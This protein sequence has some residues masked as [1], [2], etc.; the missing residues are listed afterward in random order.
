MNAEKQ[1]E[2][3]AMQ[4]SL[5]EI[6]TERDQLLQIKASLEA[7]KNAM[8]AEKTV[9]EQQVKSAADAVSVVVSADQGAAMVHAFHLSHCEHNPDQSSRP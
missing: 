3:D 2:L 4:V 1:T 7:E 9:L 5:S 8:E 6:T